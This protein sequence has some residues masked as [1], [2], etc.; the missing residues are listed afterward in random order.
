[1]IYY[2]IIFI[3]FIITVIFILYKNNSEKFVP[4]LISEDINNYNGTILY[5]RDFDK[6]NNNKLLDLDEK[7]KY[8][9]L[10]SNDVKYV[11]RYKDTKCKED[12]YRY[13]Y[14]GVLKYNDIFDNSI[15]VSNDDSSYTYGKSLNNLNSKVVNIEDYRILATND[16]HLVGSSIVRDEVKYDISNCG[17]STPWRFLNDCYK[18][19]S[20]ASYSYDKK[21]YEDKDSI[22]YP[23]NKEPVNPNNNSILYYKGNKDK[24]L[25]EEGIWDLHNRPIDTVEH[26]IK[27]CNRVNPYLWEGKCYNSRFVNT[28]C[29]ISNNKEE[30][31][32]P[33]LELKYLG[34]ENLYNTITN[35]FIGDLSYGD[36]SHFVCDNSGE[37]TEC[38]EN[39]KIKKEGDYIKI[40]NIE[41]KT[42][43]H[44]VN[45]N[46][47]YNDENKNFTFIKE[48]YIETNPHSFYENYNKKFINGYNEDILPN[49]TSFFIECKTN[50]KENGQYPNYNVYE[51]FSCPKHLPICEGNIDNIQSGI[52][53]SEL[54]TRQPSIPSFYNSDAIKC[55]KDLDCPYNF[56]LCKDNICTHNT[57]KKR[58]NST[59]VLNDRF[60]HII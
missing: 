53:K 14:G 48:H 7:L 19:E 28:S 13:C 26:N 32:V 60:N 9:N 21:Y 17:T 30:K 5:Q 59:G 43:D 1:M 35:N 10:N 4:S 33:C 16:N 45:N 22:K 12:E 46:V 31:T 54:T 18:Q 3:L 57:I 37:L 58:V 50:Y 49:E 56:P 6:H 27:K 23:Y 52:C 20:Q 25:Y 2:L 39:S 36:Y 15:Y 11:D 8:K 42:Y 24:V 29:K 44:I 55:K 40:E 41:S 38:I 51:K 47:L 34:K